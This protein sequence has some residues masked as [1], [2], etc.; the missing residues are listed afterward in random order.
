MVDATLNLANGFRTTGYS[1]DFTRDQFPAGERYIKLEHIN[2]A[3][4]VRINA[5]VRGSN[6]L[7][8]LM[9]A[10]DALRREAVQNIDLFLP[11]MPYSRQDRVCERGESFSLKLVL[12]MLDSCQFRRITTYD[13]HSN[14]AE[15]LLDNIANLNNHAEVFW[16]M[17]E[18][19][20]S[21]VLLIAPDQG[22]AKKAQALFDA[23]YNNRIK[24]VVFCVKV[25]TKG[26]N[27]EVGLPIKSLKNEVCLVVD[28]ICDGGRTFVELGK[29]LKELKIHSNYLFVSHGIFSSGLGKL[30]E[31]YKGI[32]TT[33][34]C[35]TSYSIIKTVNLHY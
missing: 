22:A 35:A 31:Y 34:S 6:D 18:M 33:N 4:S 16:F 17:D 11:Y 14:V 7:I 23:D 10:V 19:V 25:R 3:K 30:M 26:G 21:D 27:I 20:L 2:G 32:G 12:W 28:D 9:L 8:E 13:N 29:K 24:D 5:R 1:I 15:V